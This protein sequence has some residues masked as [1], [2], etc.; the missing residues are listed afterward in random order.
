VTEKTSAPRD[1]ALQETEP[2][3]STQPGGPS[4]GTVHVSPGVYKRLTTGLGGF[5]IATLACLLLVGLIYLLTPRSDKE[6]LP[7]VDYGPQLWAI[8]ADA[9]YTPYAPQGLSA[10]WRPTSSR[11]HG[12]NAGG[13]EPVHWHLGFVTPTDEYAAVEQSNERA[14]KFIPRMTSIKKTIGTQL[15]NGVAWNRHHRVDKNARSLVR[16][17][18]GPG[19]ITIVVTGTA[20]FEEL[21]V[22]A[23]SLKPQPKQGNAPLVPSPKP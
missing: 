21:G 17:L 22:L 4:R 18:P 11:L 23:A 8:R 1:S 14:D 9:P 10:G 20:G 16:T 12:L 6:L 15:V 13:D 19:G 5:T 2:A 7:T 3:A